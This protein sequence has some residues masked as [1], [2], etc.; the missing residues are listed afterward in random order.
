MNDFTL[1]LRR[2]RPRAMSAG[3]KFI[4]LR[5]SVSCRQW[6]ATN[7]LATVT[8]PGSCPVLG[9]NRTIIAAPSKKDL[10]W[11]FGSPAATIG[12][13]MLAQRLGDQNR[14]V[15]LTSATNRPFAR[16]EP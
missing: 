9:G 11:V 1:S 6:R 5:L 13:L 10:V 2:E 7:S 12:I 16:G 14:H 15:S 4:S 8:A 3:G